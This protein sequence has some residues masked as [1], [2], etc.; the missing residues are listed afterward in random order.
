MP[1]KI[2]GVDEEI[3]P[4]I[5][6]YNNHFY[7]WPPWPLPATSTLKPRVSWDNSFDLFYAVTGVYDVYGG[8]YEGKEKIQFENLTHGILLIYFGIALRRQ[9]ACISLWLSTTA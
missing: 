2:T 4:E 9:A 5:K 3:R 8:R 6:Y 7:A 1:K